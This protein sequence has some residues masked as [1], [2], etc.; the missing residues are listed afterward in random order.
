MWSKSVGVLHPNRK[1][2][3]FAH[4]KSPPV[5]FLDTR[6]WDKEGFFVCGIKPVVLG[7]EQAG[8]L[9]STH[10]CGSQYPLES[11]SPQLP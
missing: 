3:E 8:Q 5:F 4:A 11:V 9:L 1:M 6:C 10:E 7:R 2:K